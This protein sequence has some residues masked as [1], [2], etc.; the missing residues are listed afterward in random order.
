[1]NFETSDNVHYLHKHKKF[2][3][4][5][6]KYPKLFIDQETY[7]ARKEEEQRQ[8]VEKF[9]KF[10]NSGILDFINEID[11]FLFYFKISYI[12]S[13]TSQ[14]RHTTVLK[15]PTPFASPTMCICLPLFAIG[16]GV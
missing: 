9:S 14:A 4:P 2:L 10:L 5:F 8:E 15:F 3:K 7:K 11:R 16:A 6:H 13:A 1:M 12:F